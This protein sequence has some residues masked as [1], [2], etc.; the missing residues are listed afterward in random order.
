MLKILNIEVEG[1]VDG[2][3]RVRNGRKE[4]FF[5]ERDKELTSFLKMAENPSVI[6]KFDNLIN[7]IG[8]SY[9]KNGER[10]F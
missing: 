4:S 3:V 5:N 7:N 10:N 9:N 1:M 8:V 2:R 6:E